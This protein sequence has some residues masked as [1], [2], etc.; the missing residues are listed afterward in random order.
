M[1]ISLLLRFFRRLW[2]SSDCC[3][4]RPTALAVGNEATICAALSATLKQA[5]WELLVVNTLSAAVDI[6]QRQF[7]PVVLY[8]Q[9]TVQDWR[10]A[11]GEL[12]KLSSRPCV[13][14][15]SRQSD[16][17]LLDEVARCGGADVLRIP[18][19]PDAVLRMLESHLTIWRAQQ[20][21]RQTALLASSSDEAL[22]HSIED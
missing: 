22:P 10:D 19:T 14:L 3:A 5:G 7:C 18:L 16:K 17:N 12:S 9:Q 11:I 20:T 1:T 15:I 2:R 13:I 21:L 4:R 6:Q 8:D